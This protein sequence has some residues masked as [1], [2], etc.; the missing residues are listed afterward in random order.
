MGNKMGYLVD[1]NTVQFDEESTSSWI[2]AMPLGVYD[3]PVYG[4]IE[5]TPEKIQQ[6][7]DNVNNNVR[8]T[9]LDIDYDHKSHG[10]E[11][12]GWVKQAEAR[13]DGLWILVEWTKKAYSSIKER[14]YR[15]FSPEFDDA[16][17]HPKTKV[18]YKNVLFGGGITNRPFLKDILPLNLSEAFAEAD[19]SHNNE[20][21]VNVDPEQLKAVAKLLGLPDDASGDQI[22]GA[23]Q[24]KL[25]VPGNENPDDPN[26]PD[27]ENTPPSDL[28]DNAV[29]TELSDLTAIKQLAETNPVVKQLFDVIEAQGAQLQ[30]NSKQ[31]KEATISSTVTRLNEKAKEKGYAL[32]PTTRDA[33]S[34]ILMLSE[35]QK[36]SDGIVQAFDKLLDTG[37]VQMNEIGHEHKD[38]ETDAVKKFNDAV[39]SRM[40]SDKLSYAD[41]TIAVSKEDPQLFSEY[42]SAS[43]SFQS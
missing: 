14:A 31:L 38:S 24:V 21:A 36:V 18:E 16:W 17:T 4:E 28:S 6:F 32:P 11:A 23:L 27:K 12:A 40:D 39:K 26:D 2:Q 22:L 43:Y 19:G 33:L 10:P 30:S 3:H 34:D 7:A 15:Y 13:P 25:G 41:A 35:N 1:L 37:L 20:G 9:E 8:G 29:P 5:F 42:Q